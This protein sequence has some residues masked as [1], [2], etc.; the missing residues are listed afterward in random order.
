MGP[1]SKESETPLMGLRQHSCGRELQVIASLWSLALLVNA[2]AFGGDAALQPPGNQQ[3]RILQTD[4]TTPTRY[5]PASGVNSQVERSSI[6]T[7]SQGAVRHPAAARIYP[8]SEQQ[9]PPPYDLI[10]KQGDVADGLAN[11]YRATQP[12][13][14]DIMPIDLLTAWRL[15][16]RQNPSIGLAR[17]VVEER[18]AFL[19]QA[20][21]IALPSLNAGGNY[22]SHNGNLQRSSGAILSVPAEQSLYA[23][24]GA[25]TLAA[26]SVSIPAVRFFAPIADAWY[27]PLAARQEIAASQFDVRTTS[28]SIL[29]DVTNYYIDLLGA[30]ARF[31]VLRRSELDMSEVVRATLAF[32]QAG[33]GLQSDANR[34]RADALW[35]RSKVQAAEGEIAEASAR[36]AQLLQLDPSVALR[37]PGGPLAIV[38]IVDPDDKL[39][40]LIATGLQFRPEIAA[41]S[42]EIAAAEVRY[43]QEQ[44]RPLL[45]TIGVGFSGGTF[46]GGSQLVTPTFGNF[47]GRSDFDALAFWTL[48]NLGSGNAALRGQTRAIVDQSTSRR[49][50]SANRIRDEVASAHADVRTQLVAINVSQRRLATAEPGFLNELRR[51]R[52]KLGLPIEVLNMVD[53][54]V[55]ARDS[56]VRSVVEYDKAQFRLYVALGQPPDTAIPLTPRRAV[57]GTGTCIPLPDTRVVSPMRN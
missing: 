31:E 8:V 26:E 21:S 19:L 30:E 55:D 53:L 3:A 45:P 51:T 50:R 48:Q 5:P 29:L 12:A 7:A 20:R 22:H 34:A 57:P 52:A 6:P 38:T 41:R 11:D 39:D 15:A 54:L 2:N 36:L 14:I 1:P 46:G 13:P 47:S 10:E 18:V 17:Q 43:R 37:T 28:N 27:A 42:S 33:Q 44:M 32:A 16:V 24:G 35:L 25:R 40:Q 9:I 49:A 4:G 56:L 23:G